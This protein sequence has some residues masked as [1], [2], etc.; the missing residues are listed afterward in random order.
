MRTKR[1]HAISD[2]VAG[3][4]C[5][6]CVAC[7]K[8]LEI[9]APLDKPA[10]VL[11]QHCTGSGCGI[12]EKRPAVC[13]DWFCGWRKDADLPDH[14]RP[15][16]CGVVFRTETMAKPRT[17]FENLFVVARA[18][19]D[20]RA[21]FDTPTVNTALRMYAGQGQGTVPVFISWGGMKGI[22]YPAGPMADA[23]ERPSV[24]PY[25]T[26]VVSALVWRARY[27]RLLDQKNIPP[28]LFD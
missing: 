10:D 4:E 11:C 13:R 16:Q 28:K 24:T 22:M 25:G 2:L 15:D 12:Y 6:A 5:G 20:D 23:I 19:G 1:G 26:L 8:I 17:I 27:R 3:R 7:C 21:V 18:I 9:G 14:M